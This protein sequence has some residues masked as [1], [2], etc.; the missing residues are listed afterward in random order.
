MSPSCPY[1][2]CS[3]SSLNYQEEDI[4]PFRTY[5]TS[6]GDP[7]SKL[8]SLQAAWVAK[9]LLHFLRIIIKKTHL[10]LTPHR[11]SCVIEEKKNIFSPSYTLSVLHNSVL[12]SFNTHFTLSLYEFI[13]LSCFLYVRNTECGR[14][15][16]VA[17]FEAFLF[18]F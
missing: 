7:H 10:P 3:F 11:H 5:L 8:S 15:K 9:N 2:P 1:H 14:L 6:T 12:L 13:L 4:E 16:V 18:W 17:F